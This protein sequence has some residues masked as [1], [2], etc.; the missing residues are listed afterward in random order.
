MP[1]IS[2]HNLIEKI[3]CFIPV[4]GLGKRLRPLT[5]DVSKPCIR[6]LNRPLIEFSIAELAKQGVRNFIF[7]EVGYTNYTNLFDQYGE[8][9]GVSAKY[10]IQP[11]L[12]IKHQPNL[13][14][15]GSAHSLL[16]NMEYYDLQDLI[17][18]V[19]GDNLF[20]FDLKDFVRQHQERNAL[21][22]IALI[23]VKDTRQYGVADLGKKMRIKTFIEK[24]SPAEAPS[25]LASAGIYLLSPKIR[26]VLK[27][28]DVKDIMKERNR[29][30]FGYDF[31]PYLVESGYPL[32]GYPIKVWYDVG[33]PERYLEAMDDVLNGRLDIRVTERRILPQRNIWV[34]GFSQDSIKRRNE[35]I[36]KYK[37]KRLFLEGSVLIGRHTRLGDY[38]TISDS[39]IDNFCILDENSY[40]NKSAIMDGCR[41]GAHT[42]I[43]DSI[44]G[45]QV[46]VDSSHEHPSLVERNSVIGSTCHIKEGCRLLG[47]RVN[48][49][50][51]IPRGMT[52]I[53][54]FLRN[55][56]DIVQLSS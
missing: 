41:I 13:D 14:D 26:D 1:N 8:G 48:P 35:I 27:N 34:Q 4:G 40:I 6:F 19:Q 55:Y 32:F 21:M 29:L 39:S 52:Y 38:S 50:L 17:L 28:D 10:N 23:K 15:L 20:K 25:N 47:T 18:V 2:H 44:I 43:R 24:P 53:D 37:E 5:H 22:S 16:L 56:E 9:V 7:G 11:R 36:K 51:I 3:R 42:H 49:G 30:D 45:R 54:K 12:H 33:T 31:I 46:I